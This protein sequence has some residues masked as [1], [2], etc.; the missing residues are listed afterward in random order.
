MSVIAPVLPSWGCLQGW[1]GY[2][3]CWYIGLI[4]GFP[5]ALRIFLWDFSFVNP[6]YLPVSSILCCNV[7][8]DFYCLTKFVFLTWNLIVIW[9]ELPLHA[10][11]N[12]MVE[13]PRG[14]QS[15]IVSGPLVATKNF[16][17]WHEAFIW[18]RLIWSCICF[19]HLLSA[20]W[21]DHSKIQTLEGSSSC[22]L[23]G[24]SCVKVASNFYG[25]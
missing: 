24:W 20:F 5:W 12:L 2:Y 25:N 17:G 8:I 16:S 22:A 13:L 23:E 21:V 7:W 6:A 18:S 14:G 15:G 4:E 11:K 10:K 19:Y 9:Q 1:F 3:S